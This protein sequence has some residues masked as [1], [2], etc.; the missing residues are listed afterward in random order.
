MGDGKNT[1]V[2]H[3]TKQNS[4]KWFLLETNYDIN[5]SPGVHDNRRSV[6]ER[7]LSIHGPSDFTTD[8]MWDAVTEQAFNASRGERPIFNN[9]TVYSAVFM[10]K[11]PE[12]LKVVVHHGA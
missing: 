1:E 5:K 9:H 6:A 3:L 11:H 7:F 8:T 2:W 12:Q 4:S 10:A